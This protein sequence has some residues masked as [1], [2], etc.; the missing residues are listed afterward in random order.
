[1]G[2]SHKLVQY[3]KLG[4][5]TKLVRISPF[6]LVNIGLDLTQAVV[7]QFKAG[8]RNAKVAGKLLAYTLAMRYPFTT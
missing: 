4:Q 3:M 7:D 2:K 1:M 5:L 8:K 6:F